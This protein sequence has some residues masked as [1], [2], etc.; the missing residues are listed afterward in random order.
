MQLNTRFN[1]FNYLQIALLALF[2]G[3]FASALQAQGTLQFNQVITESFT[4]TASGVTTIGTITVPVNK[5]LKVESASFYSGSSPNNTS[6]N[7]AKIGSFLLWYYVGNGGIDK[8]FP[9]WLKTGTYDVIANRSSGSVEI[10]I[11]GIEFNVV[12]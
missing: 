3:F 8:R 1:L 2:C 9:I 6:G 4:G 7:W 10:A 11:S 5:V 12:P